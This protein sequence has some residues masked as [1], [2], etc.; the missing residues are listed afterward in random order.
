MMMMPAPLPN[1]R[2]AERGKRACPA[3]YD[4]VTLVLSERRSMAGFEVSMYGRFSD[5]HR[6]KQ[7]PE[8]FLEA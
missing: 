5:V 7:T 8:R 6:G 1:N 3:T 2:G 4:R